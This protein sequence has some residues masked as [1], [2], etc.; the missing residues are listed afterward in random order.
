ML[1]ANRVR[2]N[3]IVAEHCTRR[4]V[5]EATGIVAGATAVIP[6]MAATL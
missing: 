1:G 2:R 5:I 6:Q 4:R 3:E